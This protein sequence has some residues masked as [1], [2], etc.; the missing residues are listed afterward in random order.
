MRL[1]SVALPVEHGGWSLLLEPILL[2]LLIAPSRAGFF[3]ALAAGGAF[4]A[5]HPLR[6]VSADRRRGRRFPRTRR[7]EQLVLLYG[8]VAITGFLATA[9]TATAWQW[10]WPLAAA[11]PLAA[12]Q[13]AFDIAGRGRDIV[14]ELTGALALSATAPSLALAAGC[15][16][17]V[18]FAVWVLMVARGVTAIAYVRERIKMLHHIAPAAWVTMAL[19]TVSLAV[20]ATFVFTGQSSSVASIAF[21]VLLLRAGYGLAGLDH[22]TS[23]KSLGMREI[24]FGVMTVFAIAL[25]QRLLG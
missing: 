16:R 23:A 10:L 8:A 2:G 15:P 3:L 19:H 6:L 14:P 1:R 22:V 24:A 5:R 7:A 17:P 9:V 18:A 12:V 13:L 21:V 11:V 25:D 4:L 20:A